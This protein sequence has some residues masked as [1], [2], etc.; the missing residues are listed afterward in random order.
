MSGKFSEKNVSLQLHTEKIKIPYI[1]LE[2]YV[3]SFVL[4]KFLADPEGYIDLS[5]YSV[6]FV[7][8]LPRW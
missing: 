5:R 8:V 2:D 6:P 7:S 4:S 3:P 1:K